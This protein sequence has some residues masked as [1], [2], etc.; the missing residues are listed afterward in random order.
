MPEK[1]FV[2]AD[3]KGAFN[4]CFETKYGKSAA[5]SGISREEADA[6]VAMALRNNAERDAKMALCDGLFNK[7]NWKYPTKRKIVKGA[8]KANDLRDALAYFCGGAEINCLSGD[9]YS[10]GSQGYY[11]YVGA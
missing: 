6:H 1:W 9:R 4:A 3:G 8:K 2:E 10:V 5:R 7:E 11:Y